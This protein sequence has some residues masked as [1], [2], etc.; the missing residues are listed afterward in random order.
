MVT[1][2]SVNPNYV[3]RG[4]NGLVSLCSFHTAGIN[5]D[6]SRVNG[7]HM[8]ISTYVTSFEPLQYSP[9]RVF[10]PLKDATPL[11]VPMQHTTGNPDLAANEE[12]KFIK[13]N[14]ESLN[15]ESLGNAV[16]LIKYHP[17]RTEVLQSF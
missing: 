4:T 9:E 12:A 13:E 7:P 3:L 1:I 15:L 2:N 11:V 6:N 8:V 5:T 10:R 17:S 14:L 16:P